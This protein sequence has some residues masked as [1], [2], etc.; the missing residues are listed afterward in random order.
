MN[1][2]EPLRPRVGP[3]ALFVAGSDVIAQSLQLGVAVSRAELPEFS[4]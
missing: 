4:P 2:T 1:R 3:G